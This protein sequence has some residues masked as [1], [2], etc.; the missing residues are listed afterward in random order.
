MILCNR[1]VTGNLTYI[2]FELTNNSEQNQDI[3]NFKFD[4]GKAYTFVLHLG[5]KSVELTVE[6]V[7]AWDDQS[8]D[9]V[10]VPK[11]Q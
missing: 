9:A 3:F 11:L 10:N 7:T 8:N 6:E 1:D 5:L 2:T 4:Q